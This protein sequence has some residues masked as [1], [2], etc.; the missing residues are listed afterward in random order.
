MA[1]LTE[2]TGAVYADGELPETES[3]EVAEHL[4][5]CAGC[6]HLV[7]SLLAENQSLVLFFQ[8]VDIFETEPALIPTN[9]ARTPSVINFGVLIMAVAGAA[10]L[11]LGYINDFELPASLNWLNPTTYSGQLTLLL[12]TI[13]YLL[14]EGGATVM[15]IINSASL[16]ALNI[17]ILFG[18][19]K[20]VRRSMGTSVMLGLVALF[21]VFSSST[22]A[23]DV[24]KGNQPVT[25]PAGETVDDTLVVFGD[26]VSIDGTVTGDLIAFAR[27]IT[28]RGTVKG[29][30]FSFARRVEVDGTVEGSI[31]GIGQI[32]QSDG[33]VAR[34]LYAF[35][36]TVSIGKSGNVGGDAMM[37]GESPIINGT[38][39]RDASTF[40]DSTDVLGN[41]GRNLIA[42]SDRLS[43]LG[44]ARIGGDLTA[45]VRRNEN[46]RIDSSATIVGKRTIE[47]RRQPNKYATSSFYIWQAIWL[48][49]AFV[50][51]LVMFSLVPP[52]AR[53]SLDTGTA[54]L[55]AGGIGF[56]ALVATPIAAVIVGITLIG[57]PIGL[58]ALAL[59]LIA[60]YLA[61]IV[62]A[63]FLGRALMRDQGDRTPSM[64]LGL[65]AGLVLIFV[66]VNL[67]YV[68]AVI[69][70]LL[71]ILGLGTLIISLYQLPRWR[72]DLPSSSQQAA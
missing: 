48:A 3:R 37:F 71:I 9:A 70:F 49:A 11:A 30:V 24:R 72:P 62:I 57:L 17:L 67:P 42:R 25:V 29:N 28:V 63:Q 7:D 8:E 10:R 52:L 58:V 34:N 5:K 65:L 61:K 54:L 44:N 26:S 41:V 18:V 55:T 20:L 23:I 27:N 13:V 31:A 64:A 6:R 56:L 69:N 22:Y 21:A 68:G 45:Y 1:C 33:Q 12:N 36:Q 39:G 40:G 51:G 35:G 19:F 66:A 14:D 2:F 32:V 15:S 38:I 59:W 4:E 43:V 50:T 60:L 46:I 47:L 16:A 53:V